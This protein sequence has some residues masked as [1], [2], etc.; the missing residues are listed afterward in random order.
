[1]QVDAHVSFTQNWDVDII[2]QLESTRNEMAVLSTYL[3]DVVGS[4][5]EITGESLVQTRPIMCNTDYEDDGQGMHLR[6]LSQP[7]SY[8]SIQG[9][10][11]LQPYWAA[12]FSFSRGHFV[13]NVP[14]DWYLP[15]IFQGEE[16]AI[17]VSHIMDNPCVPFASLRNLTL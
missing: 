4:I 9:A 12:G 14:Y 2:E 5:N 16:I 13:V 10:P 7:E 3:T 6:H 1:M 8:P 11:Q 15:M 17:A